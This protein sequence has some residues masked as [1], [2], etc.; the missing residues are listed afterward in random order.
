[1]GSNRKERLRACV[2]VH[3]Q[4]SVHC[5]EIEP[6]GLALEPGIHDVLYQDQL[7]LPLLDLLLK[8]LNE[9]RPSHCLCLNDV[10]I[11]QDLYIIH[12]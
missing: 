7:S 9:R 6:G 2:C 11:Q 1:M 10:V 5:T 12:C 4:V 3:P 8:W